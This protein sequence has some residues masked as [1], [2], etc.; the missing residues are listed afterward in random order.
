MF[1]L[2]CVISSEIEKKHIHLHRI[3]TL[4]TILKRL[5]TLMANRVPPNTFFAPSDHDKSADTTVAVL[6]PVEFGSITKEVVSAFVDGDHCAFDS[7]Y[8]CCFEPIK[9]FFQMLL[10]NEAI[11][12]ELSQ[13]LFVR[14]WEGRHAIN[15]ELN[16]KSYLYTVA[17]SSAMKY[18]RHKK[19]AEK[20]EEF[21]LRIGS[22]LTDSPDEALAAE[23]LQLIIDIM[24]DKMP[25]QR[26]MVFEMSRVDKLSNG[27]ISLKLGISES[28]VRAHLHNVIKELRKVVAY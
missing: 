4:R 8:L 20:Y 28:T 1:G 23:E 3:H 26:C 27:E 6:S 19:V 12:E 10:R 7:I 21:R 5:I 11:A 16:F 22:D 14:L 17:K 25:R 18:L 24:L 13:E 9:G 15:P 2:F